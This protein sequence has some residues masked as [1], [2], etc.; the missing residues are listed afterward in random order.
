MG[1]FAA[2]T[3][4]A[5][6]RLLITF[7]CLGVAAF[8]LVRA[9]TGSDSLTRDLRRRQ[10][11]SV[12]GG[13]RKSGPIGGRISTYFLEVGDRTF[14]VSRA[15]FA[16]A[17]DAGF[18]R[19]YFL[20]RSRK[21]VNLE[22]LPHPTSLNGAT[23]RGLAESLVSAM[24]SH[25]RREANEARA[26]LA[27]VRDAVTAAFAASSAPP[28]AHE[29]DPRPLGEAIVGT[30]KN[31]LMKVTFSADGKV[32]TDMYGAQKNG[33]WSIDGAGRLRAD[34]TGREGTADASVAGD[35]LRIA[36]EGSG[37]T[38]TRE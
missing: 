20:P 6:A 28:V 35:Q 38:F 29:R 9:I 13:I 26:E 19:L 7:I 11:H 27:S 22:R 2:P 3:A 16:A 17:P 8:L 5:T 32:T 31:G 37:M 34:I 24:R 25:D 14:K 30:W 23:V 36:V 21:I 18:V 12:E 15:T 1:V 10:V 33:H 4:P